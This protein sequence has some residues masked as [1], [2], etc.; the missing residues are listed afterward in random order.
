MP[1]A[2][3]TLTQDQ[4][5]HY[6]EQGYLAI[7]AITTPE[8]VQELREVYDRLFEQNA[9]RDEGQQYDL[10]GT[11]DEGKGQSLPQIIMPSK[12]AP[13]LAE[14]K[15][16][17]NALALAKQLLGE[18]AVFQGEHAIL[19]PAKHGA[20]TPWHQD[21]A[22]WEADLEYNALSV[23][24]PLQDATLEMGCMQFIP[25]SHKQEIQPHH[26]INHDPRIHGL[27]LDE[28]DDSTAVA[29]PLPAGGASIHTNRTYHYAG[30][31]NADTPRRAYILMYGIPPKKRTDPRS[32]PWMEEKKTAAK[33]RA[34]AHAAKV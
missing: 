11:D 12:Y 4:I 6:H 2:L 24:I 29:C 25:G 14:M 5:N 28:V 34:A 20:P 7:D 1:Q 30:P 3:A 16:R 26:S 19:K 22:Y 31:N 10:A 27:E 18:E 32:F 15:V 13:E 8:E 21:E 17:K 23:W 33:A 9:G